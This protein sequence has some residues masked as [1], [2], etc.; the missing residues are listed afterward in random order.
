MAIID[1]PSDFFNPKIY[2]GNGG[3]Q[4]ITGVGFQPDWVW[5]KQRGGTTNHKTSDSVRGATKALQPNDTDAEAT[6][7]NGITAFNSDGFSLGAGGDYNSSSASQVAWNWKAGTS[8]TNDASAT[9]IGTIDSTGS[10]SQETGFSIVS[11]SGTGNLGTVAHSLGATPKMLF[12]RK[13]NTAENWLVYNEKLTASNYL[14][15]N[16]TGAS[17]ADNMWNSTSPTSSVF[18][19]NAVDGANGSGGNYIA[20]CFADVQGYSKFSSYVGNGNADGTFV[21]TGFKPAWVMVKNTN[22]VNHWAIYDNKRIGFNTENNYLRAD[23]SYAE[24]SET[25]GDFDLLSNGFKPRATDAMINSS[26]NTFIYMAFAE[27][28]FVASNFNAATAR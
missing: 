23:G 17:G 10:V 12:V 25:W 20:Y 22:A 4:S 6:D 11:Y 27:N 19:V 16:T 21:Y 24:G 14:L 3:T 13:R 18:T 26:G 2:T 5:V 8:F 7:S 15:L 9:G 28:P 1:K